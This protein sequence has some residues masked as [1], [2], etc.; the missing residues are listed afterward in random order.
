MRWRLFILPLAFALLLSARVTAASSN[1]G[2]GK[3]GRQ[4]KEANEA[5]PSP[6]Q[7]INDIFERR[8]EVNDLKDALA[9]K[10]REKEIIEIIW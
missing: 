2:A 3:A 7:E 10:R 9:E 4:R 1:G 6:L 5:I 8:G